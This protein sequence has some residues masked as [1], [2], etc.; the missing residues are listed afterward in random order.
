MESASVE[1]FV[2]RSR[3]AY[4]APGERILA[5]ADGPL[6][7]R[8]LHPSR[9]RHRTLGRGRASRSNTRR[10]TFFRS[11]PRSSD[12]WNRPSPPARTASACCLPQRRSGGWPRRARRSRAS[13]SSA[14]C[15]TS[16]FATALADG[17][18][19][20]HPLRAG[21]GTAARLAAREGVW[22][23]CSRDSA[24]AGAVAMMIDQRAGSV[25]VLDDEGRAEG[26]PHPARRPR[27]R[28]AARRRR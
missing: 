6:D 19:V 24:A 2:A 25:L 5:P 9:Q 21:A 17:E 14:P 15:T 20:A 26:H 10:A 8:S 27:P 13:S 23:P 28:D 12:R 16:S 4:F 18:R 1:T 11:A 22:W 7:V 3:Q